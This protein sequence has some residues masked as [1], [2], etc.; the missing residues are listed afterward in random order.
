MAVALPVIVPKLSMR[1]VVLSPLAIASPVIVP[2]LV[3][4]VPA[5]AVLLVP[6]VPIVPPTLLVS[7]VPAAAEPVII[8]ILPA[9]V[10][11]LVK[12]VPA[13]TKPVMVPV[14]FKA[15]PAKT[16]L[17]ELLPIDAK[18]SLISPPLVAF[19]LPVIVPKL[20]RRV[21]VLSP[22]AIASPLIEPW[23]VKVVP[24][25]ALLLELLP[26]EAEVVSLMSAPLVAVAPPV[27]VPKL[28]SRVAELSPLAIASPLIES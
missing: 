19:A 15:V 20:S 8:P 21:N 26:R 22:F 6:V 14:F 13:V 25:V 18:A 16:L 7:S 12:L 10:S 5:V 11:E 4:V 24:A 23:L 3:K 2:L 17:L 1:V 9:T 27:M 28:S